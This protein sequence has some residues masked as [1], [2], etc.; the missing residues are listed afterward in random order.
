MQCQFNKRVER[1][2]RNPYLHQVEDCDSWGVANSHNRSSPSR[3]SPT[4]CPDRRPPNQRGTA[5]GGTLGPDRVRAGGSSHG[6]ESENG[7]DREE[8]EEDKQRPKRT[9]LEDEN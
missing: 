7:S 8:G 3:N 5:P 6:V 4:L 2:S 1:P 9:C